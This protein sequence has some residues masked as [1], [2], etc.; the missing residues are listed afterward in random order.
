MISELFGIGLAGTSLLPEEIEI[1]EKHPPFAVILFAR[2]V[3]RADQLRD[4]VAEIKSRTHPSTLILIDEE[5][6]RVDRLRALYADIPGPPDCAA[7]AEPVAAAGALGSWIGTTLRSFDIDVNLAPVVD[8]ERAVP[9][10]GLE[11]RCWGHDADS[12]VR[13][14]RAFIDGQQASGV[15]S[16]LKHFPGMGLARDDPHGG[17]SVIDQPRDRILSEDAAP[18]AAL[19]SLVGAVM[20]GHCVYTEIDGE[21]PATFSRTISTDLLRGGIGFDGLAISDDMDMHA[22]ADLGA[23]DEIAERAFVAGSDVL[24]F[25]TRPSRVGSMVARFEERASCDAKFHAR[26][27]EAI[28]RARRY[29]SRVAALRDAAD[30]PGGIEGIAEGLASLRRRLGL[31]A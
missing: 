13:L 6:G 21:S 17:A 2:N 10:R 30:R 12:V 22:V 15:G 19:Q 20:I 8:I 11:R 29:R 16:C 18:F 14:A 3:E 26:V 25:C 31:N 28:D 7:A 27:G 9:P 23:A 24:L 5:G 1:L 4:L